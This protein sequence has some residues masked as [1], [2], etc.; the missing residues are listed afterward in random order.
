MENQW[1]KDMRKKILNTRNNM[2]NADVNEKSNKIISTIKKLKEFKEG[3]NIMVYLSFNNEV[4]SFPLIEY[5]KKKGKKVIIPY[6]KKKGKEIIP[7]ELKNMDLELKKSSFGYLEQKPEFLRPIDMEKI[8]L[9][10]IPGIG[11]DKKCYRLGYGA[12][13]YD[14]FLARLNFK[15][16][17]IGVCY[18]Y[19]ILDAIMTEDFDIPMDYIVTEKRIIVR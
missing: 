18:D 15:I 1:K 5:C 3:S 6:C 17:T 16:P 9:I 13:Y 19:Q 2:K 4:N 8:D 12:G 7:T 10:I 14:R 11:F